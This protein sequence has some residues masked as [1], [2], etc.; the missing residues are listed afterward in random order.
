MRMSGG[1]GEDGGGVGEDEG[2]GKEG[3]WNTLYT[4]IKWSGNKNDHSN[5][6]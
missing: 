4:S 6:L 3:D 5:T 2:C 1:V